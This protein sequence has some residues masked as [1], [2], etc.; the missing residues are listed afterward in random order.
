M[1]EL[2]ELTLKDFE[3]KA[4]QLF[5]RLVLYERGQSY[6]N[7]RN[8]YLRK[9]SKVTKTGF[10]IEG[11]DDALFGFDGWQKGLS[12]R[13]DMR[14]ISK[15]ELISEAK[16]DELRK[17]WARKKATTEA[18]IAVKEKIDKLT[19]EKLNQILE[20]INTDC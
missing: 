17:E 16:A 3:G 13:I 8:R 5:G 11:H 1:K 14:P 12:S 20:I 19:L 15:C 2:K 10:R 9:I 18:I 6:S 4:E 7:T